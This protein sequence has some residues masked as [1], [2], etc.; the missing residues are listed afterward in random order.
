MKTINHIQ[1]L[2]SVIHN[3]SKHADLVKL[4]PFC[5]KNATIFT[6]PVFEALN[7]GERLVMSE[8]VTFFFSATALVLSSITVYFSH[9]HK[10]TSI[11]GMFVAWNPGTVEAPLCQICEFVLANTGTKEVVLRDIETTTYPEKKGETFPI[12]EIE[13]VPDVLKPGE[14]K[15]YRMAIPDKYLE[16]IYEN[17]QK[18][19]VDFS[20]F[21]SNATP[22]QAIKYISPIQADIPKEDWKP[23]KAK[24]VKI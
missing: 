5:S 6:K 12:L 1:G 4:S 9:F 14:I 21:T 22:L 13:N 17:N 19:G 24:I 15:I 8:A 3:K 11:T 16:R 7:L 18:M 20:L 2:R 23:F 10:R